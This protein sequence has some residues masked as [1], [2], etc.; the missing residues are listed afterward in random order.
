MLSKVGCD[1]LT[2]GTFIIDKAINIAY[3]KLISFS[4]SCGHLWIG[5][6]LNSRAT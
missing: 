1:A 3:C 2:F 5:K 6:L 4:T